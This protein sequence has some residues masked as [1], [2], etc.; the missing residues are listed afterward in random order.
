M[1]KTDIELRK[2][3]LRMRDSGKSTKEI[4]VATGV[5]ESTIRNWKNFTEEQLLFEPDKSTRKPSIDLDKL[6]QYLNKNPF[7]FHREVALVFNCS[8]KTI[9]KWKTYLGFT[10]KKV[11]T[12][13]RESDE[14]KKNYSS[15]S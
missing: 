14:S 8:I 9:H 4:S 1:N 10:R 2:V 6:Q 5:F 11:K 13:Y 15:K 3:Y 12:T 7:A